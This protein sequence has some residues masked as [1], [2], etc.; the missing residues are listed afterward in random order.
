MDGFNANEVNRFLGKYAKKTTNMVDVMKL[1]SHEIVSLDCLQ[2][3][4]KH[5]Y[6]G[7][8]FV[9]DSGKRSGMKSNPISCKP[10]LKFDNDCDVIFMFKM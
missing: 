1:F 4:C 10:S 9:P 5:S 6:S 8:L 3:S 7:V 2:A